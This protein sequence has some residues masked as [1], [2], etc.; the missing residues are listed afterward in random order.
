MEHKGL[1]HCLDYQDSCPRKCYR[2][3]LVRDL[4]ATCPNA[5][6]RWESFK[7]TDECK[8]GQRMQERRIRR[9]VTI[10]SKLLDRIY[11]MVLDEDRNFSAC[12]NLIIKRYFEEH[13]GK[14]D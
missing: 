14:K 1:M 5:E 12:V 7:G 13:D 2:A 10:E 11:K 4:N 9:S 3:L 6:V 8:V